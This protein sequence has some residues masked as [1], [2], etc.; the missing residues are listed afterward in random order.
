MNL[1]KKLSIFVALGALTA[2]GGDSHD[3]TDHADHDDAAETKSTC[4]YSHNNDST[5]VKW[6]AFKTTAKVGVS[7]VFNT[8][9]VSGVEAATDKLEVYENASFKIPVTSINSNNPDR[10]KKIADHFFGVMTGTAELSGQIKSI[11][12]DKAVVEINMN[13]VTNSTSMEVAVVGN[14]ISLS[15]SI[16]MEDWSATASVDSLNTVCY[17]LHKG[18]DGESKLWSE[19]QLEISTVLTAKDCD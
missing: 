2:C 9:E 17:D 6:T 4:M 16:N 18:E 10:D 15:G 8:I 19:V 14:K 7:G 3:H 11:T 12:E 13:G 1:F 5:V